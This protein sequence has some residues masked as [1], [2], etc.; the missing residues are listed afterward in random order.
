M[1]VAPKRL[2]QGHDEPLGPESGDQRQLVHRFDLREGAQLS[3]QLS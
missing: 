3:R 1:P 2:Q